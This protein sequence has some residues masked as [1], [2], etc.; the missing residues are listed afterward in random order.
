MVFVIVTMSDEKYKR[1]SSCIWIW[2]IWVITVTV[3]PLYSLGRNSCWV[4]GACLCVVQEWMSVLTPRFETGI[5]RSPVRTFVTICIEAKKICT[6]VPAGLLIWDRSNSQTRSLVTGCSLYLRFIYR[7]IASD[8]GIVSARVGKLDML[9]ETLFRRQLRQEP[10]NFF[11]CWRTAQQNL[12]THR[13]LKSYCAT[14]W[15]RLLVFR[16]SV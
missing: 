5:P 3:R 6:Y 2:Q 14:L 1:Q 12:R 8:T 11:L 10:C 4:P 15:W 9:R 16:F 7:N 13:I